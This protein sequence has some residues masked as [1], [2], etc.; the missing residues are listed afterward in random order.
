[1]VAFVTMRTASNFI[2]KILSAAAGS[3]LVE[4]IGYINANEKEKFLS[5]ITIMYFVLCFVIMPLALIVQF[6]A[7]FIF[8]IWTKNLIIFDPIVFATLTS[9]LLII[10]FYKPAQMIIS[11]K[12]IYKSDFLITLITGLIYI[13]SLFYL[14]PKLG[15][16]GAG[17]SL[18][19]G[20]IAYLII[21]VYVAFKWLNNN[22]ISFPKKP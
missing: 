11:G 20:Q 4:F 13:F 15:I 16:R 12:N 18:F 7:P 17:Y 14:V 1:M 2:E 22:F 5:I 19:F 8:K 6:V 9:T 3:I 10:I 21:V